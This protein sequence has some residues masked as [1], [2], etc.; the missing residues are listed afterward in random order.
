MHESLDV[1]LITPLL[2]YVFLT[3]ALSQPPVAST[4]Q[5]AVKRMTKMWTSDKVFEDDLFTFSEIERPR[6]YDDNAIPQSLIEWQARN[7]VNQHRSVFDTP[8]LSEDVVYV[9]SGRG[10]GGISTIITPGLP[11]RAAPNVD[12]DIRRKIREVAG[13][14][15][16]NELI[17]RSLRPQ[18][19]TVTG[20]LSADIRLQHVSPPITSMSGRTTPTSSTKVQTPTSAKSASNLS[21]KGSPSSISITSGRSS[22]LSIASE[23]EPVTWE[24]AGTSKPP[25]LSAI[26]K[27]GKKRQ[28][29]RFTETKDLRK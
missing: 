1:F 16:S 22:K 2:Q 18:T 27:K 29:E 9:V 12:E 4:S 28:E 5:S 23:P 20:A 21:P 24:E 11:T 17:E 6:E 10:R 3:F 13:V 26:L 19:N 14:G 15:Y 8:N 7:G 25:P